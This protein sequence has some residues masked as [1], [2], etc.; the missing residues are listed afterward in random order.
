M[1]REILR[2]AIPNI[3]SNIS[4]PL[5]ST[6][7]TALMGRL[8]AEHL[9]AVGLG[10]MIFN[11][12]YWNFGFL[13]MGS[14]G[15]TAQ[16]FGRQDQPGMANT[17]GRALA[18]GWVLAAL[19][20]LLQTPLLAA[21]QQLLEVA[22][23][24]QPLVAE[25][26]RIR[27]LAAPAALG[28]YA[29]LGWFFGMQNA[30]YPLVLT[31][32]IN[33]ANIGLSVF[34]VRELGWGIRGVA[35]GTCLAQYIGLATGM[36]L[37]LLRYPWV[38]SAMQRELVLRWQALRPF[39][40]L[41]GDIFLRT[42]CLTLAF[43][44]FYRESADDGTLVLAANVILLQYLNWM[45]YGVDGFAFAAESLVGKYAGAGNR[46]R[47]GRAIRLSFLWGMAL[48][49]GYTLVYGL[50]GT[51][52]LR[53]FTNQP[54]VILAARP[55]LWW[56]IIFPLLA[57]PCYIWDGVYIGLTAAR[58]MRNTMLLAFG[59]FILL[60]LLIGR[61]WGNHGLWGSLLA[62]MILRG[63]VQHWWFARGKVVPPIAQVPAGETGGAA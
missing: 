53:V 26:F 6:F 15:L 59:G 16:A 8:S 56:M 62:F 37:L 33:L 30:I 1:H 45:S 19:L 40:S 24:Q 23:A 22:P 31:I 41:N 60:Y 4:V 14:T 52:L 13:R 38:R 55:Y 7:D 44:F 3:L 46:P 10:S 43:A 32:V 61:Q 35:W 17:L 36:I 20:L 25:Y 63:A 27:I 21:S 57:T 12:L 34:F 28:L 47:L 51:G 5:L 39:L 11:F 54:E 42:L 48:A 58:A 29:M 2:L 50:G 49:A 9:G 18:V